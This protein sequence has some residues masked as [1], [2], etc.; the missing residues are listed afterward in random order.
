MCSVISADSR[1]V[2]LKGHFNNPHTS[3]IVLYDNTVSQISSLWGLCALIGRGAVSIE[4]VASYA[5]CFC[6]N[7][8]YDEDV[9]R[10][11]LAT[12]T[13]KERKEQT[14]VV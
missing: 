13:E 11:K 6:V 5:K 1:D 10:M 9:C 2:G 12:E 14:A 7:G 3:H 4:A 8:S